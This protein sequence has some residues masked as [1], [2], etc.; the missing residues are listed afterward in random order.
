MKFDSAIDSVFKKTLK[1]IRIK[2]DPL[3]ANAEN[4]MIIDSYEGYILEESEETL[5]V[6]II[7]P[8]RP[9]MDIPREVLVE[10]TMFDHFKEFVERRLNISES[11][12][13]PYRAQNLEELEECLSND[14]FTNQEICRFYREFLENYANSNEI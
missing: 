11:A 5:K 2:V 4:Y 8:G 13:K 9:V 7:K 12:L 10:P 1:K 6:M 3:H 14:G